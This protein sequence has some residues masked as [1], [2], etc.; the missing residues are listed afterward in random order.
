MFSLGMIRPSG[1]IHLD[2]PDEVYPVFTNA[3]LICQDNPDTVNERIYWLQGYPEQPRV[4]FRMHP[5]ELCHLG[6]ANNVTMVTILKQYIYI[7]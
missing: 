4:D 5:V 1:Q 6:C 3:D 7:L 2:N